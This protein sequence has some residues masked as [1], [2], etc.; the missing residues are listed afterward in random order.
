MIVT[1]VA[2]VAFAI[3]MGV[4]EQRRWNEFAKAH[5]C[6]KIAEIAGYYSTGT[7]VMS[8]GKIGTVSTWN[9]SR[10]TYRCNDGVDYTR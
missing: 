3:W 6:K 7:G 9:P 2:F 10:K 4:I 5:D 8:N 1:A